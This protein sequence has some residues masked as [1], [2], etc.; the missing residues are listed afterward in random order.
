MAESEFLK[1]YAAWAAKRTPPNFC[2]WSPPADPALLKAVEDAANAIR[3]Q[4]LPVDKR[5]R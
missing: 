2:I 1:S 3:K 5:R 4:Q